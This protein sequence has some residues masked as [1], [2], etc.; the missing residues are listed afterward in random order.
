MLRQ[1]ALLQSKET[2]RLYSSTKNKKRKEEKK[3]KEKLNGKA[4]RLNR[5]NSLKQ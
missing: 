5:I 4:W 3:K 1:L 2:L